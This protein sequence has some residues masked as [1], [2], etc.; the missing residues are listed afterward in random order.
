EKALADWVKVQEEV[1]IETSVILTG[2]TGDEFDDLAELYLKQYPGKFQLYCGLMMDGIDQP[3]YPKK[4]V[5]EL[6][7]CFEKGAQGVGEL[8]DKG[9]GLTRDEKLAP[10]ERMHHDDSRL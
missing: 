8:S 6:E 10:E 9:F 5:D 7:R 2:A 3:D 4:A 1:G